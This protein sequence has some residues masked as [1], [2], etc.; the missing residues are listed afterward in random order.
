MRLTKPTKNAVTALIHL[1]RNP[2][3]TISVPALAEACGIT[4]ETAF[5]LVPLLVR[6][7]FAETDRGRSGGVRIA[8]PAETI[9][10]GEIV[11]ALEKAPVET[12]SQGTGR[13]PQFSSIMDEAY[14]GFLEILDQHSI[15]D[16]AHSKGAGFSEQ[17]GSGLRLM[18]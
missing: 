2:D 12:D 10:I 14:G 6:E 9:S 17:A 18:T 13:A 11:R 1:A 4:G 5:K 16:L 7:G 8:R 3:E 15:A